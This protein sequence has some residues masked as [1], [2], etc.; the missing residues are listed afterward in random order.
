MLLSH[1]KSAAGSAYC[2]DPLP[3]TD[4]CIPM[5]ANQAAEFKGLIIR[6]VSGNDTVGQFVAEKRQPIFKMSRLAPDGREASC[7]MPSRA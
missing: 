3:P 2:G 4:K 6:F 7:I 5:S 1:M